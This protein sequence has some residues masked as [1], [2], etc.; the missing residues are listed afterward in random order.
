MALVIQTTKKLLPETVIVKSD[1][2]ASIITSAE[3]LDNAKQSAKKI[4]YQANLQ[5]EMIINEAKKCYEEEKLKGREDGFAEGEKKIITTL[6]SIVDNS[7]QYLNE[8]ENSIVRVIRNS[9]DKILGEMDEEKL[10]KSLA[11]NALKDIKASKS[12]KIRVFPDQAVFVKTNVESFLEQNCNIKFIDVISDGNLKK[13]QCIL[14]T[15]TGILDASLN[16]QLDNIIKA[17]ESIVL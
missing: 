2:Y 1:E 3:I 6:F 14:E 15:D 5:S 17:I 16:V 12:V 13:N 4:V 10:I 8:I 9:L 7:I 11:G